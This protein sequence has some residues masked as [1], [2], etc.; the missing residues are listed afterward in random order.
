MYLVF[1]AF[2]NG[3]KNVNIPKTDHNKEST[4]TSFD[5]SYWGNGIKNVHFLKSGHTRE[6][7]ID[8]VELR[9]RIRDVSIAKRGHTRG[10]TNT[11]IDLIGSRNSV[12]NVNTPKRGDN[13]YKN[14]S[15]RLRVP[16]W[17]KED[18]S[19]KKRLHL[20]KY[21]NFI[22]PFKFTKEYKEC[23]TSPDVQYRSPYVGDV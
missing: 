2:W 18:K 5:L 17:S 21:R 8:S 6:T 1:T 9:K 4:K 22:Y 7:F 20:M 11:S 14:F 10:N 23:S 15:W 16:K 13:Q 12:K 3:V 19:P